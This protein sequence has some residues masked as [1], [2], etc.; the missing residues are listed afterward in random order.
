MYVSFVDMAQPPI[1]LYL[2]SINP[3]F[4]KMYIYN[5]YYCS[6]NPTTMFAVY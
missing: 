4:A 2:T 3:L 6:F 5:A 1:Q